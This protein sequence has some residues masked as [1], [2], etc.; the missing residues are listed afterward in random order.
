MLRVETNFNTK[1]VQ[2]FAAE[3]DPF[4]FHMGSVHEIIYMH[5]RVGTPPEVAH[6]IS[7]PPHCM[8]GVSSMF[9]A[10]RLAA[11]SLYCID[12]LLE[13]SASNKAR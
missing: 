8:P 10:R 12:V 5:F 13:R 11:L 2:K 6:E 1:I 3:V 9:W 4:R 7:R